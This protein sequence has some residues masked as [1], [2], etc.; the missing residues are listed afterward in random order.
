MLKTRLVYIHPY[1]HPYIRTYVPT[2]V[3]TYIHACMHAD[4]YTYIHTY[5]RTYIHTY[6]RTY[7]HT[8][9]CIV[10]FC[11]R[12]ANPVNELDEAQDH[13]DYNAFRE[14]LLELAYLTIKTTRELLICN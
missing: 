2:Y 6:V 9:V 10:M 13:Q 8:Y 12:N 5:V 7:I 4:I 3:H 11:Y 1:I 14:P